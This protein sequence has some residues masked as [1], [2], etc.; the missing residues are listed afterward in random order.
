MLLIVG[1]IAALITWSATRSASCS[2]GSL[3]APIESLACIRF[4]L[5][6]SGHAAVSED[7]GV[8]QTHLRCKSKLRP[9]MNAGVA[10]SFDCARACVIIL[11]AYVFAGVVLVLCRAVF[12]FF[13]AATSICCNTLINANLAYAQLWHLKLRKLSIGVLH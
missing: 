1:S 12:C 7:A 6:H 10:V 4:L 13:V 5:A 11:V 2:S 8:P 3:L 9:G